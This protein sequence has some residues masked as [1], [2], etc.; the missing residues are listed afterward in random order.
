MN[1][2]I[3]QIIKDCIKK[4]IEDNDMQINKN[5]NYDDYTFPVNYIINNENFQKKKNPKIPGLF[6]F[7]FNCYLNSILQ[8]FHYCKDFT[9]FFIRKENEITKKGGKLS[10]AYLNLILRLNKKKKYNDA[11]ILFNALQ[12]VSDNFFKKR[13]NDPKAALFYLLEN[14][15]NELKE[16]SLDYNEEDICCEGIEEEDVFQRCKNNE[17]KNKSIISELFNWCLLT[18]N[19]CKKCGNFHYICEYQNNILIELNKYETK[20]NI[21]LL[22]DLIKFYFQDVKKHFICNSDK[23]IFKVKFTKKI[24]SLPQYLIII[25]NRNIIQFNIIYENEI[26]LSEYCVNESSAKYNFIGASLTNDYGK[27]KATHAISRC[28]TSEGSYIFNDLITIKSNDIDGYNPYILFYKK[29]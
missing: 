8:C 7:G 15:H 18:K 26:D 28:I 21:V 11:K 23:E 19:E 4:E 5:I 24:K 27:K 13:G 25:L 9:N 6:N 2:N 1:V 14:L 17:E 20:N 16:Q 29:K 3:F 22:D 12:E 10:I